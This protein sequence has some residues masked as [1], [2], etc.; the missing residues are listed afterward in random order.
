MNE[1]F[2]SFKHGVS[3]HIS[4]SSST[5]SN[6]ALYICTLIL[7]AITIYFLLPSFI[8]KTKKKQ[9]KSL[10]FQT[11]Y[12]FNVWILKNL[13]YRNKKSLVTSLIKEGIYDLT[14]VLAWETFNLITK[15]FNDASLK[16]FVKIVADRKALCIKKIKQSKN[17][18]LRKL[19]NEMRVFSLDENT[20]LILGSPRDQDA[21]MSMINNFNDSH[22]QVFDVSKSGEL[23]KTLRGTFMKVVFLEQRYIIPK[24]S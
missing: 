9:K 23:I 2:D 6:Y 20:V 10:K 1:G 19:I 12:D 18:E 11:F 14:Q 4:H 16:P 22:T 3:Q 7:V 17:K 13:S 15:N 24:Y 8:P 5:G 21:F